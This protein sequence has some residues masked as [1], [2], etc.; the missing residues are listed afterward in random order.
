MSRF[1]ECGNDMYICQKCGRDLC[2]RDYPSEWR[3]IPGKKFSGNI[4]PDCIREQG[5]LLSLFEHCKL[6]SG[7]TQTS[8]I[9][10][11]MNRYYGH[12]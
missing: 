9:N 11:Y 12:G 1:C 7:L 2:S 6:E 8:A 4:C 5:K 3:E 10:D